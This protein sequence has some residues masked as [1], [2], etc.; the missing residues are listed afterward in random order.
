M[1][2]EIIKFYKGT[3]N[4]TGKIASGDYWLVELFIS[5]LLIYFKFLASFPTVYAASEGVFNPLTLPLAFSTGTLA[6]KAYII[7]FIVTFLPLMAMRVRRLNDMGCKTILA[8]LLILAI[9]SIHLLTNF[10]IT[11]IL[12]TPTSYGK[13]AWLMDLTGYMVLLGRVL[14]V[15]ALILL[16]LP[17]KEKNF[18]VLP[19]LKTSLEE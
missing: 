12:T 2:A 15:V 13:P 3:F 17:H 4:F 6:F 18:A 9:P 5:G 14:G 1:Q 11:N 7:F 8:V 10:T 16:L 19:T